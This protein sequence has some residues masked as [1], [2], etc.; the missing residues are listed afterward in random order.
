MDESP[1]RRWQLSENQ[2][3]LLGALVVIAL[4]PLE[5]SDTNRLPDLSMAGP[6]EPTSLSLP[7][8]VVTAVKKAL[9]VPSGANFTARGLCPRLSTLRN[10]S[11]R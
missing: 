7:N 3:S 6:A 10:A 2:Q 11:S 4:L 9:L 8:L 5:A 1:R